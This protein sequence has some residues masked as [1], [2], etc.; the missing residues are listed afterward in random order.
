MRFLQ[1]QIEKINLT[2]LKYLYGYDHSDTIK[3]LSTLIDA[4]K[5]AV[6]RC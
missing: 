4:L 5:R 2:K 6:F 3:I 1:K